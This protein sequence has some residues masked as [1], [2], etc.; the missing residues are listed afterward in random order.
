MSTYLVIDAIFLVLTAVIAAVTA[1]MRRG[2]WHPLVVLGS[3]VA[4]LAMTI[5]FDNVIIGLGLV[6]YDASRITG[7]RIGLVPIED[8]G[9]PIAAV[10]IVPA[11]GAL[12]RR[13]PA[14]V[15]DREG[16]KRRAG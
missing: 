13:R 1:R 16:R 3:F 2:W 15:D 7:L 5:V 11:F 4:L 6:D 12:A 10:V 8:L 9:Y 14:A